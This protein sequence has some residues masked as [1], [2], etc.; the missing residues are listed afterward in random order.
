[1]TLEISKAVKIGADFDNF[2]RV[3]NLIEATLYMADT[4]IKEK[5]LADGLGLDIEIVTEA[6][7][8]LEKEYEDRGIRIRRCTSGW[9]LVTD[10]ELG[11]KLSEFFEYQR[12][13]RLSH[14]A[15]ETLAVIGYHQPITRKELDTIRGVDS[16]YIVKSLLERSLIKIVS[17]RQIPGLPYEYAVS[18]SFLNHFGLES[19]DE[20]PKLEIDFDRD[21][22]EEPEKDI[23]IE[24]ADLGIGKAEVVSREPGS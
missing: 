22:V 5:R 3:Q 21:Q 14:S 16:S 1:M 24:A 15:M 8:V 13:R 2:K 11:P 17:Q 12:K 23:S 4:P 6:L 18:E 9:E 7:K 20:L 10:H 19:V